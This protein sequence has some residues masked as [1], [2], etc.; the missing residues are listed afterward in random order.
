MKLYIYHT[1]LDTNTT[2][3]RVSLRFYTIIVL[4]IDQIQ[5]PME[6]GAIYAKEMEGKNLLDNL[7]RRFH[8]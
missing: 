6:A 3:V 2:Q 1:S 4:A 5:Q 7:C 8:F